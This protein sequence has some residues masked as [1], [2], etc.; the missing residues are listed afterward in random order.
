MKR[1][2]LPETFRKRKLYSQTYQ[3]GEEVSRRD[4]S[5]QG[6]CKT[7]FFLKKRK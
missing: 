3:D 7:G 2:L 6:G 4:I 1:K 5:V